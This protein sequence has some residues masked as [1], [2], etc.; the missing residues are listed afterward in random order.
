MYFTIWNMETGKVA[1]TKMYLPS[2]GMF[3]CNLRNIM[4]TFQKVRRPVALTEEFGRRDSSLVVERQ[5][6]LSIIKDSQRLL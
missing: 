2:S 3:E 1:W 6:E 4:K 5:T